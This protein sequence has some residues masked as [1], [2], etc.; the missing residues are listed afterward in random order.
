MSNKTIQHKRS[1]VAGNRPNSGQIAVGE[2]AINFADR[3]LYTKDGSGNI[4][5][6]SKDVWKSESIPD[7][8]DAGDL[9]FNMATGDLNYLDSANGTWQ[10]VGAEDPSL[11]NLSD[12]DSNIDAIAEDGDFIT[13]NSSGGY[14]TAGAPKIFPNTMPPSIDGYPSFEDEVL[15]SAY[16][17]NLTSTGDIEISVAGRSYSQGPEQINPDETL[18]IR[19]TGD[20]GTGTG[21]D[22]ANG[23]L[24]EGT[25]VS[26][27][28]DADV[29]Y[30][31]LID[32]TPDLFGLNDLVDQEADAVITSGQIAGI[33]S[34]SYLYIYSDSTQSPTTPQYSIN[35]GSW[36][37]LPSSVSASDY[38]GNGVNFHIRHT[39]LGS[40]DSCSTRLHVGETTVDWTTVTQLSGILQPMIDAPQNNAIDTKTKPDIVSSAY[41]FQGSVGNHASSDWQ[42]YDENGDLVEDVS[43]STSNKLTWKP[44]NGLSPN[45]TYY[46]RTRHR[47]TDPIESEWSDSSSFTTADIA[48]GQY[49]SSSGTRKWTVPKG[50]QSITVITGQPGGGGSY[51]GSGAGYSLSLAGKGGGAVV[52]KN[53]VPVELGDVITVTANSV[54]GPGWSISAGHGTEGVPGAPQGDFSGGGAGGGPGGSGN[55]PGGGGQGGYGGSGGRGGYGGD[56]TPGGAGS[57]GGAGGGAGLKTP[58]S[59]VNRRSMSGGNT[60]LYGEGNNGGGGAAYDPPSNFNPTDGGPGSK[61]GHASTVS[62][63]E[64]A[65]RGSIVGPGARILWPGDERQFPATRTFNETT[66]TPS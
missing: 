53:D 28:T 19:W 42:L 45:S 65:K 24:A 25:I 44:T 23:V 49:E 59:Y 51:L 6:L 35:G 64:G 4:Q 54:S 46:V 55:L 38:V 21:R 57:R 58:S 22:Q 37:N 66:Y 11:F 52:W 43:A 17:D 48:V 29:K 47:S 15:W 32:K 31:L 34:N 41:A 61:N 12:V 40:G 9:W 60:Y 2:L 13:W 36:K 1:S 33:N 10:A 16:E 20:A 30:E 63:G 50:V 7:S 14:W 8:A 3:S 56:R 18:K 27:N 5:V 26:A 39:S 62:D